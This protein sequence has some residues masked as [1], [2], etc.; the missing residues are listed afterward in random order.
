MCANAWSFVRVQV[1]LHGTR[2]DIGYD[3]AALLHNQTLDT[4]NAFMSSLFPSA[5]DRQLVRACARSDCV[6]GGVH[7]GRVVCS[8]GA[9]HELH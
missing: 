5:K 4:F 6:R 2:H 7:N 8:L 3:Y 9:A 1:D